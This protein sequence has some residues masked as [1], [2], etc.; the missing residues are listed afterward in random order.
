MLN[1]PWTIVDAMNPFAPCFYGETTWE[2]AKRLCAGAI[3]TPGK[4]TVSEALRVMG[5]G[6]SQQYA[7]YHQ[8][9][10]RAA[11]SPLDVGRVMVGQLVQEFIPAGEPLVLGIDATIER[12]WGKKV[13]ARGI[14][15]DAVRS[16]QSHFVKASGL[17]WIS[18]MVQTPIAWAERSWALPIMTVVA[19]SE[20]YYEERERTPRLCWIAVYRCSNSC[21]AGCPIGS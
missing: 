11:W 9:L 8:V 14:Y 5:L 4:R 6:E 15:R 21:G 13:R 7:Q 12:R 19:P 20:C 17:R 10:N 1:L 16:S 2:K 3:L 18:L